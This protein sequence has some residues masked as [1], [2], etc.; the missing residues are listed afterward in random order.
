MADPID[1]GP[2]IP[3]ALYNGLYTY[4]ILCL[5]VV[6]EEKGTNSYCGIVKFGDVDERD[7]C[8]A[9][10][11]GMAYGTGSFHVRAGNIQQPNM[12]VDMNC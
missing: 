12:S 11:D 2:N 6:D 4:T 8:V 7:R 5:L 1:D 9:E 3:V 10:M